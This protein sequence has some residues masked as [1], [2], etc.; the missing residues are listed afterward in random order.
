MPAGE[1]VQLLEGGDERSELELVAGQIGRLLAEGMPRR[2]SPRAAA[3]RGRLTVAE[4]LVRRAS[5]TRS[6]CAAVSPTPHRPPLSSAQ[7]R[8]GGELCPASGC[9]RRSGCAR[10][11]GCPG[12]RGRGGRGRSSARPES[13]RSACW[14]RAP[15][16]PGTPIWRIARARCP[17]RAGGDRRRSRRGRMW[18]ERHWP[19]ERVDQLHDAGAH[20]S[21]ST[22]RRASPPAVRRPRRRSASPAPRRTAHRG[23][24][25]SSPGAGRSRSSPSCARVT[26]AL[27]RRRRRAGPRFSSQSIS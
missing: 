23:P 17:P 4:V 2:R 1:A 8:S 19:V 10:R 24:Q 6:S 12:G 7:V 15:G 21:S 3:S 26:P 22:G 20:A 14:L 27:P 16:V 13:W 18:E 25:R 5:P 9:P 11:S